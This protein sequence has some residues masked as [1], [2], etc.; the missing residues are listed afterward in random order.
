M[1]PNI[2][3]HPTKTTMPMVG[4]VAF[5]M[6][7]S[8]NA[9]NCWILEHFDIRSAFLHERHKYHHPLYIREPARADGTYK[10]EKTIVIM[11]LNLYG[12]PSGTFYYVDGLI[13]YLLTLQA[14]LN[15]A[16]VCLARMLQE[17]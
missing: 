10:H 1:L 5:H 6:V 15:E 14:N 9:E 4:R 16:Y 8:H 13:E 7:N 2:H 12:N 3:Y 11:Q 17:T